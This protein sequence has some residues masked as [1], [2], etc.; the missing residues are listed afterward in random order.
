MQAALASTPLDLILETKS[1]DENFEE[2]K[3]W[4]KDIVTCAIFAILLTAPTGLLF[5]SAFGEKWL[6]QDNVHIKVVP[7]SHALSAMGSL[8]SVKDQLGQADSMCAGARQLV[9]PVCR[10]AQHRVDRCSP[11]Y[12]SDMTGMWRY[13]DTREM[14]TQ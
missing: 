8:N 11:I 4:G 1:N 7:S 13:T 12:C 6:S 2:W 3:K 14:R 9:S 5:I 10:C